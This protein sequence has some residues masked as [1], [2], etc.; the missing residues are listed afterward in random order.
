MP[1]KRKI[2]VVDD[3]PSVCEGIELVLSPAGYEVRKVNT[4]EEAVKLVRGE[5]FDVVLMD[6]IMP[7]MDGTEACEQIKA[8]KPYTRVV[9][10]SGS[11]SGQRLDRFL[12]AGG[13]ELYLYK[14]FGKQELIEGVEKALRGDYIR[15]RED[16]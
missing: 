4:G 16:T 3:E 5:D 10:I 6:L 11:P 1:E 13:I 9:A 15:F 14:P 8:I 7:G 2:L 12:R